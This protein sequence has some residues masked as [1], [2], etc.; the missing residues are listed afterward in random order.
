MSQHIFKHQQFEVLCGWDRRLQGFFLVIES[1]AQD[2]PMYSNL[3]EDNPHPTTFVPF[4]AVLKRFGIAMPKGL[5]DALEADQAANMGNQ[6][7]NW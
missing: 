3:Y 5:K 4:E 6:V 2:E 7:T 1:D